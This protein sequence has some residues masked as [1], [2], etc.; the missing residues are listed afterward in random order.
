MARRRGIESGGGRGRSEE[1]QQGR[2]AGS[3]CLDALASRNSMFII[4]VFGLECGL[5]Q[6]WEGET[7][8]CSKAYRDPGV[9]P[10]HA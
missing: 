1:E 5:L 8:A 2:G 10:R 3:G 4:D 6:S 9:F 7:R